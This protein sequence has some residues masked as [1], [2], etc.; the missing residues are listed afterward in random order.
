M[1][2]QEQGGR[3]VNNIGGANVVILKRP[4][5]EEAEG[6]K[7]SQPTSRVIEPAARNAER[8]LAQQASRDL[9][10]LDERTAL[11]SSLS[12]PLP[13]VD[14]IEDSATVI[15]G[16]YGMSGAL[17]PSQEKRVQFEEEDDGVYDIPE[18]RH[19]QKK[20]LP[21]TRPQEAAKIQD[22]WSGK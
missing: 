10:Q 11:S 16:R 2:R 15:G 18:P 22:N 19:Y 3:R 8:Q 1:E 14:D 20:T 4:T 5:R 12:P 17:P 6:P 13:K 9:E 7:N 21:P